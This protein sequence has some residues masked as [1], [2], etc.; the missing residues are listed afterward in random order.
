MGCL[1]FEQRP[2]LNQYGF[3]GRASY[4]LTPGITPFVEGVIDRREHDSELDRS[5]Y[6]RDSSGLTGRV[7]TTF[8]LT[9]LLTGEISADFV[10]RNYEDA[11]LKPLHGAL[12]DASL[13]WLATPLTKATF[14]AKSGVA[15]S[16]L[17]GVSGTLTRDASV[18]IDHAFRRWLIGTAKFGYGTSIYDGANRED[19]NYL[20]SAAL[21][22]KLTRTLHLKGEVRRE[23]LHS[24]GGSDYA[25]NV[26]LLGVRLQ[27]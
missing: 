16:T 17:A 24:Q 10:E 18:Q 8:E 3:T 25:A 9:R 23:W 26:F 11:R 21:T 4:E 15:E 13:V 22:Y 1:C 7:G 5:G 6:Q 19:Q 20:L 14:T 2:Q 27:R 12:L